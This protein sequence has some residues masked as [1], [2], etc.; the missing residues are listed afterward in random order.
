M[1]LKIANVEK[2]II[3]KYPALI[4]SPSVFDAIG[5]FMEVVCALSTKKFTDAVEGSLVSFMDDVVI[6]M[7]DGFVRD[8][9]GELIG[10]IVEELAE[11][12][13]ACIQLNWKECCCGRI[14]C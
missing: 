3:T 10:K 9:E 8:K 7:I 2:M 13:V 1:H 6:W 5:W 12:D 4:L 11:A 14:G